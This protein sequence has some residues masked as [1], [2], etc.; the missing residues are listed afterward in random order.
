[1]CATRTTHD[2]YINNT[3]HSLTPERRLK[4]IPR[5]YHKVSRLLINV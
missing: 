3:P 2:N 1:M 4:E 5:F